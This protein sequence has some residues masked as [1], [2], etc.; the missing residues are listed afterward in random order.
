MIVQE[1]HLD[2]FKLIYKGAV[3]KDEKLP[4]SAYRL[5]PA[6]T[7]TL[8]PIHDPAPTAKASTEKTE[9]TS[10]TTIQQEL[11]KTSPALQKEHTRLGEL[12]LQALLR[13]DAVSANG[14]WEDARRERKAAVKEVQ[15]L[16]DRLDD[17]WSSR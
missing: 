1:T 12:L 5:R 13:L 8:L 3:L 7:L 9:Q 2:D 6:S 4:L 17:A 11:A 16:L 14:E 10:L 15:A